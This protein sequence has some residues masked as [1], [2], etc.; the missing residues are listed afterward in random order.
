MPTTCT[1]VTASPALS[2][3]RCTRR[4]ATYFC[5]RFVQL[6]FLFWGIEREERIE[7]KTCGGMGY[8]F[9]ENIER[10]NE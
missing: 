9:W 10:Q 1:K 3:A 5:M 2:A 6:V 7:E 8:S 4:S